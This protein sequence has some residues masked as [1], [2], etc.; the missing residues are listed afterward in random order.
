MNYIIYDLEAT[1]W[2]NLPKD[3][4]QEIIEI[5]ACKVNGYGEY[6]GSYNRFVKP[7]INPLLSGFCQDLTSIQQEQINRADT[8]Q[9]VVEEFQDW[10]GIFDEDYLLCSWGDFDKKMLIQDCELHDLE[11]EWC[12]KHINVKKQYIK[13]KGFRRPIGLKRATIK[14]GFEFE[15][16]HHRGISDA[17]NLTK[18]FKKY[19]D[20]W[21]Y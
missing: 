12:E 11:F 18:I 10:I 17:E 20:E 14:E 2:Q 5:G 7:V 3:K 9:K 8:F 13:F 16:I 1:C 19:L 4:V 6:L 15:G 21:Q